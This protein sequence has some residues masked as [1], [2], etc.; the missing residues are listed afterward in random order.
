MYDKRP[1]EEPKRVKSAHTVL[2]TVVNLRQYCGYVR[3][4]LV[5]HNKKGGNRDLST[6]R[7][8]GQCIFK[9]S[10]IKR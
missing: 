5:F 10:R 1:Y 9:I 6:R 7:I 8:Y 2:N 3:M 4:R